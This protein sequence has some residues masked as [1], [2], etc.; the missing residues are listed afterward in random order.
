MSKLLGKGALSVTPTVVSATTTPQVFPANAS[1][2]SLAVFNVSGDVAII[3]IVGAANATISLSP[4]ALYEPQVIFGNSFTI[5]S[6][7]T[8][9]VHVLEG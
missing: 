1:R 8:S 3:T 7:T 5:E 9:L 2:T 6:I 4:G